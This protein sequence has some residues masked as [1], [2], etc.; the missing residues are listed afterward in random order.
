MYK[1]IKLEILLSSYIRRTTHLYN[2]KKNNFETN[3]ND[4]IRLVSVWIGAVNESM[5]TFIW[6]IAFVI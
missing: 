6:T 1:E 4:Q 5:Q 2:I 3:K